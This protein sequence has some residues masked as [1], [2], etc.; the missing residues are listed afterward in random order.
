MHHCKFYVFTQEGRGASTELIIKEWFYCEQL[1]QI[2]YLIIIYSC[3]LVN[4]S[5]TKHTAPCL[6]RNCCY[7]NTAL[8]ANTM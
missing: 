2:I 3:S 7:H 6:I 8:S 4:N 1:Q 5:I